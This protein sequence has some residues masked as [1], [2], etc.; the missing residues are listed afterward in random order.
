M[1]SPEKI[2]IIQTA[3]IGDV[4]LATPLIE[5]VHQLYPKAQID[6]MVRKGNESLLKGHPKINALLVWNKKEQKYKNLLQLLKQVR[7]NRYDWVLNSQRYATTGWFTMLSKGRLRSGFRQ[8]PFSFG[9]THRL[10]HVMGDFTHETTRNLMLLE[11]M[12]GKVE[13]SMRLYPSVHDY[14]QV[15]PYQNRKYICVAPSSVWFTKQFPKDKWIAFFDCVPP[16]IT[17]YLLGAPGDSTLCQE[18]IEATQHQAC[19]NLCGELSLLAS[20]ALMEKA[21]M[22]Y[23][24]DS[25]P[26]HLASSVDAATTA[27]YC[28]TIPAFGFGPLSSNA[29]VVEVEEE[30]SCRPCGIHGKR[31][32]PKGH[33]N[34]AKLVDVNRLV[35]RLET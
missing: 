34:C 10:H 7:A 29:A 16:D 21:V 28:S 9:F 8:N 35:Q 27:V 3:F 25:A 2:L 12:V 11:P 14:Q 22:N 17:I 1:K 6:F 13:A 20:A 32:C 15:M 5:A 4:I 23:V 24:N 31:S 18:I 26:M 30:L 33:F 19:I